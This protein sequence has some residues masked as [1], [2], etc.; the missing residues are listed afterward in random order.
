MQEGH[1]LK[2]PQAS[3]RRESVNRVK[4]MLVLD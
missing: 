3:R 4:E 2:W 1:R